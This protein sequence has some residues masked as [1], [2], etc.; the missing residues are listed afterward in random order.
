MTARY[1]RTTALRVAIL[2][3]RLAR[4]YEDRDPAKAREFYAGAWE[5]FGIRFGGEA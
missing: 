2:C 5:Q 3:I 4:Y 1:S